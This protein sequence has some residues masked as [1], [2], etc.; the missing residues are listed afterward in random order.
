MVTRPVLRALFFLLPF[1]PFHR[2]SRIAL[3][4]SSG[5]TLKCRGGRSV[6]RDRTFLFLPFFLSSE[7]LDMSQATSLAD[8]LLKRRKNQKQRHTAEKDR[9]REKEREQISESLQAFPCILSARRG[10]IKGRLRDALAI[11][12]SR[13]KSFQAKSIRWRYSVSTFPEQGHLRVHF[14]GQRFMKDG[15]LATALSGTLSSL[16]AQYV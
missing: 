7:K 6:L 9:D 13:E 2:S 10:Q 1:H 5:E 4:R 11:H 16:N 8:L 15:T 3:S 12:V 14:S